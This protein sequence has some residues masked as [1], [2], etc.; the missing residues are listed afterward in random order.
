MSVDEACASLLEALE[1]RRTD[2][3]KSLLDHLASGRAEGLRLQE[4]LANNC[5]SAGTLLHHAVQV[6]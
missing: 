3:V 5:T 2:I 1:A 4:V 6:Q